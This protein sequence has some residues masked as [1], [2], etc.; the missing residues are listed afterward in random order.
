[1]P[2]VH[3][4][5]PAEVETLEYKP[6]GQRRRVEEQYDAFLSE[7]AAGDY[8]EALLESD[9]KRLTVRNRLRAAA[10]RR[11]VGI[12]FMRT[13]G[14][15]V[16]FKIVEGTSEVTSAPEPVTSSEAASP[17]E[18]ES[19]PVAA[20]PVVPA[21]SANGTGARKRRTKRDVEP[22]PAIVSIP[23]AQA[24]AI[25]APTPTKR[26]GRPKKAS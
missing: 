22:P 16:R 9:E 21:T 11:G 3:K 12:D 24:W 18:P 7:Y 20:A 5:T 8:G 23:A 26:R 19:P 6:T 4:L 1:M 10:Q 2:H 13:T 25:D 14:D 15:I 17:V